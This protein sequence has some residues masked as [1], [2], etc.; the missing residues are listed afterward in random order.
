MH[1]VLV[2]A[3]LA[4]LEVLRRFALRGRLR[5]LASPL[6]L[7]LVTPEM[8]V[9]PAGLLPAVLSGRLPRAAAELPLAPLLEQAGARWLR[10]R[11]TGLD[12]AR[13]LLLR[14]AGPPLP[15][16][17]L[18][19]NTGALPA[20]VPPGTLP[21]RPATPWLRRLDSMPEGRIAVI[22]AGLAGVELALAL[23]RR[24]QRRQPVLL[25]EAAPCLLPHLPHGFRTRAEAALA[26]AGVT[27]RCGFAVEALQQGVLRGPAGA[28]PDIALAIACTGA[29]PALDLAG[30]GVACD[31]AGFPLIDASLR[32]ISH[33]E[34]FA[35]GDAAGHTLPRGGVWA[36]RAA[37]YLA[38]NLRRALRGAALHQWPQAGPAPTRPAPAPLTLLGTGDGRAIALW[39]GHALE[40]R[41]VW[42]WKSW[43]DRRFLRRYRRPRAW[44]PEETVLAITAEPPSASAPPPHLRPEAPD[45][46]PQK[47]A[48]PPPRTGPGRVA[49]RDR[50]RPP[51][52]PIPFLPKP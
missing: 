41:W 25:L 35:S 26:R 4:H 47:T 52:G 45:S 24:P 3:G 14:E 49:A 33:P 42:W 18:S 37:P 50:D 21:L 46:A 1:L 51:G 34:I 9:L 20:P 43:R 23:A 36:G 5:G 39:R 15:Y 8:A 6:L 31:A 13:R 7:T 12:P 30:S 16:D 40:G 11:A 38:A 19:I 10:D 29:R 48:P 17:L 27:W 28:E 44:V 32:S 22:G 2:G